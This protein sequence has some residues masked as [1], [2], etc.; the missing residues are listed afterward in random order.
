MLRWVVCAALV[1]AVSACSADDNVK[2]DVPCTQSGIGD[3]RVNPESGP[4]FI[5]C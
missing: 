5:D 4:Y 1:I 3:I 2:Q